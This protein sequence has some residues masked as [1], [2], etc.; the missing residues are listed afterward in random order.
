MSLWPVVMIDS[1]TRRT[2]G[3]YGI[4][5]EKKSIN[6]SGIMAQLGGKNLAGVIYW[7]YA[8]GNSLLQ[9]IS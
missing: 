9:G 1:V 4:Y 7:V 3:S 8:L 2:N 6:A 5:L